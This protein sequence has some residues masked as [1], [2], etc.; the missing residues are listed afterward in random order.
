MLALAFV[1]SA[2][3]GLERQLRG[4][5]AGLRTHT[6][7]GLGSALFL[8][9][10]KYGFQNVV[11]PGQVVVDP[12]G[13]P[14]QI[15]SGLGFIG[16]GLIFVQR[17]SVRGL[18]ILAVLCTAG[19]FTVLYGLTPLAR[20]LSG[21]QP[22]NAVLS[23][24][25][26]DGRGVLR[27]LLRTCTDSGWAVT[28]VETRPAAAAVGPDGQSGPPLVRVRL[29]LHGE[30]PDTGLIAALNDVDGVVEVGSEEVDDY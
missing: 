11:V 24:T 5:S 23:C 2:T 30:G 14:A 21:R 25:Y 13:G 15:V 16:A 7:V 18:P 22:G 1:L 29:E 19:H 12:S 6:I 4:K 8:L 26:V 17:G 20:R 27:E 3:I 9:V 10:S 28:R